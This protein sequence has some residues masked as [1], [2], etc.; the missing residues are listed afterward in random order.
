MAPR[1]PQDP[2]DRR[3]PWTRPGYITAATFLGALVILAII[4]VA[5]SGSGTTHTTQTQ[6]SNPTT[7]TT[8]TSAT[9]TASSGN[10]TACTLAAGSQ[11]VPS[12]SPPSGT[13]WQQ[14]GSMS[15]PQAP[16]TLGPQRTSGVF[17]TCFAHSPSGALLAAFNL[18]AEGTAASP[19]EV[20]QKLAIG[21]PKDLGNSDRLDSNGPVQFAAYKYG[22]Y[23]SSKANLIIVIKGQSGGLEGIGTTMAWTG[24]DWRYVFPVN[25][26]PPISR[27]SDLTGY[28][29]WS[30][31]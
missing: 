9:T 12:T 14:V 20:F 28:V 6:A 19:S 23:S 22:S 16:T 27:L 25:G 21:A 15:T 31:F 30:A 17:N 3:N 2:G 26:V 7:S 1:N 13:S 5:T 8:Q 29:P 10:P 11:S 18:W 24:T 4:L